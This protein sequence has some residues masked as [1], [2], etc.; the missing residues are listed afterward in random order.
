M[1]PTKTEPAIAPSIINYLKRQKTAKG[2]CHLSGLSFPFLILI[3]MV[4]S[5][6]RQKPEVSEYGQNFQHIFVSDSGHFRGVNIGDDIERVK[7]IEKGTL[8]EEQSNYLLY[9]D[10]LDEDDKFDVAY[11]F[12]KSGLYT[13]NFRGNFESETK[14]REVFN[15]FHDYYSKVYGKP[16]K[17]E[18]YSVWKTKSNLSDHIEIALIN[19]DISKETH[20]QKTEKGGGFISLS[21]MNYD[22]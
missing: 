4:L 7:Q 6:C 14:S 2:S 18:A 22:Y 3:L 17:Q 8:I 12:D 10:K 15:S 19:H 20:G 5:S 13:I 11:Y 9:Q 21:I 1:I 16:Q